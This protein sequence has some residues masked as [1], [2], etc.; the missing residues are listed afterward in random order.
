MQ[1]DVIFLDIDGVL[2]PYK[3]NDPHAFDPGCVAQFRR[4]LDARPEVYVV[5]STTW[6]IGVTFF[7]LGWLWNKHNLP[8]KRVIGRTPDIQ[9]DR[10]GEEIRKWLKDA[11]R[12]GPKHKVRRYA[13]LDDEVE[14]IL[15]NIPGKFVFA[16]DPARGLT[17][18][19]ADRMI[20][21]FSN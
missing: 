6:R 13:V 11:P 14:P 9:F 15:K 10:R 1:L 20:Q 16:C 4:I 5:F 18:K 2:N 8:L 21:Y 12:L 19:T 3:G 17:Q 7:A